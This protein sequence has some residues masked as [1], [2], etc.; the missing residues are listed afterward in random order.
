MKKVLLH[1]ILLGFLIPNVFDGYTLYTETTPNIT[2]L[3]DNDL[4]VDVY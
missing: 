4:N 2:Y 1:I 3:I